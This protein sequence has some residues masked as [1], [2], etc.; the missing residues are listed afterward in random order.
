MKWQADVD[1]ALPGVL[2]AARE[3][4]VELHTF[5]GYFGEH[6]QEKKGPIDRPQMV[7][8][9]PYHYHALTQYYAYQRDAG[10]LDIAAVPLATRSRIQPWALGAEV[11]GDGLA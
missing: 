2:A 3:P 5:G 11:D 9:L 6:L 8:G 4:G 7:A 10:I 1:L